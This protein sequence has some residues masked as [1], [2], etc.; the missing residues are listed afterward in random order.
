MEIKILLRAFTSNKFDLQN[1]GTR[2][3]CSSIVHLIIE[4]KYLNDWLIGFIF[5]L[6]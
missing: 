5:E 2:S 4:I 3:I 1:K 6:L